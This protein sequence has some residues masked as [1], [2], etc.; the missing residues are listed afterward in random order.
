VQLCAACGHAVFPRRVLCPVCGSR[1]WHETPAGPGAV[2]QL[3]THRAGG[4]VVSVK[5][6]LGPVVVARATADLAP[7]SRVTLA[8]DDGTPVARVARG[9]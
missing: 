5:L 4:H 6:D 7:G 1:A 8:D 3:T 2:E 9:G